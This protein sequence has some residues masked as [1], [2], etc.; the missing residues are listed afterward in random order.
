MSNPMEYGGAPLDMVF[1]G[2]NS[3]QAFGDTRPSL[4]TKSTS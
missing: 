1:N 3:Q 2:I 4:S